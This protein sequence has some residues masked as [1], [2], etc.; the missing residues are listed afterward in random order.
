MTNIL[1]H[2]NLAASTLTTW[3]TSACAKNTHCN[4]CGLCKSEGN[5]PRV[6]VPVKPSQTTWKLE[7]PYP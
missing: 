2:F 4:L 6:P 5:L 3:K 7:A 1:H